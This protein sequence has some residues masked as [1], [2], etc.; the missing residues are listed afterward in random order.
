MFSSKGKQKKKSKF[1]R[2]FGQFKPDYTDSEVL[3]KN[4]DNEINKTFIKINKYKELH[5]NK[6]ENVKKD[7]NLPE[8][9]EII[10]IRVQR[11]YNAFTFILAIK[12]KYDIIDELDILTFNINEKTL[13]TIF[14]WIEKNELKKFSLCVSESVKSRMPK[15]VELIKNL[16][17]K[18]KNKNILIAFVWNHAKIA[19]IKAGGNYYVIEGSGNYSD[20][21]EVEQYIFEN[22]KDSY[23]FDKNNLI[24]HLL[25]KAKLQKRSKRGEILGGK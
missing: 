20:N 12:E 10:K 19:L 14:D 1:E 18:N 25:N 5:Y 22:N 6:I 17:T 7:L 4:K 11:A 23:D 3:A 15:R 24:P 21:E 13:L 16:Y 2:S 9:G 8:K